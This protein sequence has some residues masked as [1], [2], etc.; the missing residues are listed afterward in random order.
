MKFQFI[1]LTCLALFSCSKPQKVP[2]LT[3]STQGQY[4]NS[5][6]LYLLEN[7][8][9]LFDRAFTEAETERLIFIKDSVPEG[10]YQLRIDGKTIATLLLNSTAPAVIKGDFKTTQAKL[11]I[12]GNAQTAALWKCQQIVQEIEESIA[13]IATQIPDSV[14]ENAY[15]QARDSIYR[16]INHEIESKTA[17]ILKIN[18]NN[19]N[20]LLPLLTV[21]MKAG[22]HFI[23]NPTKE[24]DLI[25]EVSNQLTNLYPHYA[26][27]KVFAKRVDSLMTQNVFNSITKEGRTLPSL[28]IPDAWKQNVVIDSLVTKPTLFVL[29]KSDNEASRLI[30]KQI[31]RWSRTYRNQG[32]QLCMISFDTDK[33]TW[34]N[35]IKQDRLAVQHLSDL[36]GESSPILNQLGLTS[37]PYL[38]LVDKNKIIV[39][40]TKELEELPVS[41]QQ[42]M[43]N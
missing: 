22:N 30:T 42:L 35:A 34:L 2:Y 39:K 4:V 24:S 38:I 23:I 5:A 33:N 20:S 31:M 37:I 27:V 13:K 15:W 19:R 17:E 14:K 40:R 9:Q 36:K 25:Y 29:W 16:L 12:T 3:L 7:D 28:T 26:P 1:I 21:Q 32:L 43:K 6:E 10:I 18:K 41:V 11:S 8:Y